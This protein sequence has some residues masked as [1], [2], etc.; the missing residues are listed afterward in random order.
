MTDLCD[1]YS[2]SSF[3]F[4]SFNAKQCAVVSKDP[5]RQFITNRC[6]KF[7][8]K[9]RFILASFDNLDKNQSYPIVVSGKVKTG[10]YGTTIQA[11]TPCFSFHSHTSFKIQIV[12]IE[13]KITVF[14]LI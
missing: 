3:T 4:L 8:Q 11:V 14:H 13:K 1:K 6:S 5:L 9:P 12:S 7:E 10:F 2:N